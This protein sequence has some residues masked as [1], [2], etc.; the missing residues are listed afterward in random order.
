MK[1]IN[2]HL[3]DETRI[4]SFK[5]E[6]FVDT[7][8]SNIVA[9]I[10]KNPDQTDKIFDWNNVYTIETV[11][12]RNGLVTLDVAKFDQL[13]IIRRHNYPNPEIN[14][15][16]IDWARYLVVQAN[17]DNKLVIIAT[18][19]ALS[20]HFDIAKFFLRNVIW[21]EAN[22]SDLEK[23]EIKNTEW[24]FRKFIKWWGLININLENKADTNNQIY[25]RSDDFEWTE[26]NFV[27]KTITLNWIYLKHS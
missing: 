11:T 17:N 1:K 6:S 8:K 15:W 7:F 13:L 12:D 26:R 2:T 4:S 14:S 5:F 18:P 23:D 27:I 25:S 20:W 3:T 10:N 21:I 9:A 16:F 19:S 24:K 22:D